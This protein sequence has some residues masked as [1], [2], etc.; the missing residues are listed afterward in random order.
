MLTTCMQD[1]RRALGDDARQP[2]YIATVHRRGYQFI[3]EVT[4]LAETAL[5]APDGGTVSPGPPEAA[6]SAVSSDL[7]GTDALPGT[8]APPAV[9]PEG[10]FAP[11]MGPFPPSSALPS[12]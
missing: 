12:A 4:A 3:A 8:V 6:P 7:L 2:Q 1:L 9:E 5:E 11:S 10:A